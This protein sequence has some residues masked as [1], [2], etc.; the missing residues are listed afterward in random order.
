MPRT[1]QLQLF[2]TDPWCGATPDGLVSERVR[3]TAELLEDGPATDR[4]VTVWREGVAPLPFPRRRWAQEDDETARRRAIAES[5]LA[6]VS[7]ALALIEHPEVLGPGR[8]IQ[9]P[10]GRLRIAPNHGEQSNALYSRA[11]GGLVFFHAHISHAHSGEHTLHTGAVHDIVTHEL[12]HA[13]LDALAPDLLL[14]LDP[15]SHAVHEAVADLTSFVCALES[16]ALRRAFVGAARLRDLRVLY[17]LGEDFAEQLKGLPFLRTLDNYAHKHAHKHAPETH[18]PGPGAPPFDAPE[19]R[20]SGDR[21]HTDSLLLS[22]ALFNLAVWL[23]QVTGVSSAAGDWSTPLTDD[24]YRAVARQL[25]RLLFRGLDLLPPGELGFAEV[26]RAIV[27]VD[28]LIHKVYRGLDRDHGGV[29]ELLRELGRRGVAVDTS[30][31][32]LDEELAHVAPVDVQALL[33]DPERARRWALEHKTLLGV[34]AEATLLTPRVS[35]NHRQ[36]L[37]RRSPDDRRWVTRHHAELVVKPVW[38]LRE[39]N[40]DLPGVPPQRTVRGGA[41]VIFDGEGGRPLFVL[42]ARPDPDARGRRDRLV[43]RRFEQGTLSALLEEQASAALSPTGDESAL[44]RALAA[45]MFT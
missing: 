33:A 43:E 12:G 3:V 1:T 32:L 13:V 10:L 7:R 16:P 35:V 29:K 27:G 30:F 6:T 4:V 20:I 25:R 39:P 38:A 15:E 28:R 45:R 2:F 37:A 11:W 42:P 36:I 9:F 26:A 44:H 17:Q 19:D 22:G 34:P 5:A 23:Q 41:T 31:D 21:P 40:P 24:V 8:V 14:A 18:A